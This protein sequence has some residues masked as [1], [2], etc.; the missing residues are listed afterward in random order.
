MSV[1]VDLAMVV[2]ARGQGEGPT[3]IPWD[4]DRKLSKRRSLVPSSKRAVVAAE[5]PLELLLFRRCFSV[6]N[7]RCNGEIPVVFLQRA[8][9]RLFRILDIRNNVVDPKKLD[10]TGV[11]MV[12]WPEFVQTWR[13]NRVTVQ[14]TGWERLYITLEEPS[15]SLMSRI[16]NCL[17]MMLIILSSVAFV[18]STCPGLREAPCEDCE[19]E[20]PK[21]FS[22]IEAICVGGFSVEY[23]I[24]ILCV[25]RVRT[26]LFDE[27][28]LLDA[29]CHDDIPTRPTGLQRTVKFVLEPT[30]LIDLVAILPWYLEFLLTKQGV[31]LSIVRILR[32]TRIFR[33]MKVGS[34]QSAMRLLWLTLRDSL[35]SLN[36]LGFYLGI[37]IVLCSSMTY[38]AEQGEWED[39]AYWRID[40]FGEPGERSPFISIPAAFWWCIVTVTAV[41]YGDFSPTTSAG[42]WIAIVTIIAGVIVLALPVGV[43]SSNFNRCWVQWEAEQVCEKEQ[44]QAELHEV[45]QALSTDRDQ[46]GRILVEMYDD[47][48]VG[49]HAPKD[50]QF[51]GEAEHEL[52]FAPQSAAAEMA[53]NNTVTLP[54]RENKA[55]AQRPVTGAVSI[56][57]NWRPEL[58]SG[59]GTGGDPEDGLAPGPVGKLKVKVL[60]ANG[61]RN[62]DWRQTGCLADPFARVS[63]FAKLWPPGHRPGAPL[64]P[65]VWSTQP[66]RNDLNPVFNEEVELD[67]DWRK[68]TWAK[69]RLSTLH[70]RSSGTSFNPNEPRRESNE[71]FADDMP[72]SKHSGSHVQSGVTSMYTIDDLTESLRRRLSKCDEEAHFWKRRYKELMACGC[73]DCLE[74][75]PTW[76]L[77]QYTK[78][79]SYSDRDSS[80]PPGQKNRDSRNGSSFGSANNFGGD[81]GS[82][83]SA[84]GSSPSSG[85]YRQAEQDLVPM[86]R[87][88]KEKIE[89]MIKFPGDSGKE[90][91]KGE[92]VDYSEAHHVGK[93]RQGYV[94]DDQSS[95]VSPSGARYNDDALW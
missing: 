15:S 81:A 7:H 22:Y 41:G 10:S 71:A 91:K 94:N 95:G 9:L 23:L 52:P 11:G 63:V 53:S 56:E 76:Q 28:K 45:K 55:K 12:G 5:W 24:R 59:A 82:T 73:K 32:L 44:M 80:R 42:K 8:M 60:K 67:I 72:E 62:L 20:V 61:L 68:P 26:E 64:A 18:L 35:M 77:E 25:H 1:G 4:P 6:L 47:D 75:E 70:H 90:V 2:A 46:Y 19:P 92:R 39:G 57:L 86:E 29:M 38:Y 78:E 93:A 33:I 87:S 17:V 49:T 84:G 31:N 65:D 58:R 14:I 54:L 40:K 83:G 85:E 34:C 37:G 51:L 48:G 88:D 16:S 50:F 79:A 43:I 74:A 69:D 3:K 30:N 36:V 21:A 27:D 89:L 13:D 66:K